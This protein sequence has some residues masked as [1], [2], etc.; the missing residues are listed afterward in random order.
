MGW[1]NLIVVGAVVV[2]AI[3][4]A[5]DALRGN[6]SHGAAQSVPVRQT[7]A[8]D[9]RL[10]GPA[11]PPP[12][13]LP[14]SLLFA[15]RSDCRL[16]LIRFVRVSLG[17]PGPETGCELWPSPTGT[18]ALVTTERAPPGGPRDLVLVSVGEELRLRRDLGHAVGTPAWSPD[19]ARMAWCIPGGDTV[20]RDLRAGS[21]REVGGC[22]PAFAADGSLLTAPVLA[23][24][25]VIL[26]DGRSVL[27]PAELRRGLETSPKTPVRVVDFDASS[28][29]RIAVSLLVLE[30]TGSRMV[31]EL[32]RGNRLEASV[33]LPKAFAP[34]NLRLGEYLRF[35]P[36]GRELAVGYAPRA[37]RITFVDLRLQQVSV[38]SFD[39]TGFAWSPDGNWLAV[40]TGA[41]IEIYGEVRD[42]PVFTLP[43]AASG[44]GW[45]PPAG[46]AGR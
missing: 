2:V 16:R 27:D 29:G 43:I 26:G 6:G 44:L 33:D 21:E 1:R 42:R 45:L 14:G 18:F 37:G 35:S 34:G 8:A 20:V 22:S 24:E 5:V 32:W 15:G 3:T 38:R 31:L 39:Q 19:G 10:D 30:P 12:G 9:E 11:V 28:D 23:S 13:V 7:Q 17:D 41:G 25:P 4:A 46:T 36:D 40:A